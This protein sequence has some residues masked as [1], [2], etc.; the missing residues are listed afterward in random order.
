[1]S[2]CPHEWVQW[3]RKELGSF[4]VLDE[5]LWVPSLTDDLEQVTEF[6]VRCHLLRNTPGLRGGGIQLA[7]PS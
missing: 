3:T 7:G 6:C 1:M 2:D 5:P 4:Y